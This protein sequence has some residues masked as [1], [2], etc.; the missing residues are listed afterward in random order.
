M[1]T[2]RQ[3]GKHSMRIRFVLRL[4]EDLTIAHH[5]GV[6]SNNQKGLRARGVTQQLLHHRVRLAESQ[7]AA[8]LLGMRQLLGLQGLINVS[9]LHRKGNA[10][11][12]QKLA[13]ARASA[14]Q[15]NVESWLVIVHRGT[16]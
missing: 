7:L 3:A 1:G 15:N 16:S 14:G 5:H 2:T 4:A 12:L 10:G 11:L 8:R 6:G 13:A 9:H